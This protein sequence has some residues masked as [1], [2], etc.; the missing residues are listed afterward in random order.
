MAERNLIGNGFNNSEDVSTGTTLTLAQSGI[1]QNITASVTTAL[2]AV[3]TAIAGT[4]YII[5]VG[6]PGKTVVI[7]CDGSDYIFGG[8]IATPSD[9]KTI[10][11]TNQPAGSFVKLISGGAGSA[12][13]GIAEVSGTI[14]RE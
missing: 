13:Y 12:G 14:T 1:V 5:R 2:P 6:A 11:F 9:G 3:A 10:T 7:D 8:G 4:Q